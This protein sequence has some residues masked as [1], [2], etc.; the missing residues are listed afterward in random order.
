[1]SAIPNY[2]LHLLL[3]FL[4]ARAQMSP[5]IISPFFNFMPD[6]T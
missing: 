3:I 4:L 2:L 6:L 5:V 1:M